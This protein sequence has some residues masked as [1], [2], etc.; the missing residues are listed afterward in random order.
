M[1]LGFPSLF[2]NLFSL[3][4]R[5]K[6]DYEFMDYT[7]KVLRKCKEFGFKVFLDPHQDVVSHTRLICLATVNSRCFPVVTLFGGLWR[8][9]LDIT[10]LRDEP[11]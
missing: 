10:R 4:I 1:S 2:H 9:L 8:A 11:A 5:G 3:A 6:Y 7:I